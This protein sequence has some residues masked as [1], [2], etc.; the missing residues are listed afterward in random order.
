A[1]HVV[2]DLGH[3]QVGDLTFDPLHH[4]PGERADGGVFARP[5]EPAEEV[6]DL[7]EGSGLFLLLFARL[8]R[9]LLGRA[10]ALLDDLGGR[11]GRL[12]TAVDRRLCRRLGCLRTLL[13]RLLL[14][15]VAVS[16]RRVLR[17][18]R[19]LFDQFRTALL[20]LRFVLVLHLLNL[21]QDLV[22][23]D[24][25]DL[26][27][28]ATRVQADHALVDQLQDLAPQPGQLLQPRHDR[29]LLVVQL[30]DLGGG[31][32]LLLAE[33]LLVEGVVNPTGG[34]D[35]A[36]VADAPDQR[37]LGAAPGHQNLDLH[38][39]V[40][41]QFV[42]TDSRFEPPAAGVNLQ[43]LGRLDDAALD[44]DQ[45]PLRV[46]GRVHALVARH[47]LHHLVVR[48]LEEAAV[49]ALLDLLGIDEEERPLSHLPRV[50]LRCCRHD[51]YS[52]YSRVR[53]SAGPFTATCTI[54]LVRRRTSRE[55]ALFRELNDLDVDVEHVPP[56]A[57]A[58]VLLDPIHD[59]LRFRK[60][61][62]RPVPVVEPT[63]LL[64]LLLGE[65]IKPP[66]H[67][68]GGVGVV[69]EYVAL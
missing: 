7:L 34:R 3:A 47:Q 19:R 50:N 17:H 31:P 43:P 39:L 54:T 37:L 2:H 32:A 40:G 4:H 65:R 1:D 51:P 27:Q 23:R 64:T 48:E 60:F 44:R 66:L 61:R 12:L 68:F 33:A 56:E 49:L 11:F 41:V 38:R 58:S 14:V 25:I 35:V 21:Q 8:C 69:V 59:Y 9:R 18:R 46:A 10:D 36:V 20:L 30:R 29:R 15:P 67:L 26:R 45:L 22:L 63:Q 62:V 5:V 13:G 28:V 42:V 53:R 16:R 52:L 55:S 24:V 57:L 6:L